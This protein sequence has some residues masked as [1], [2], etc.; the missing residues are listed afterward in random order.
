MQPTDARR[1][2]PDHAHIPCHTWLAPT[3]D[4]QA[5]DQTK[6]PATLCALDTYLRRA[7]VQACRAQHRIRVMT[8]VELLTLLRQMNS[9]ADADRSDLSLQ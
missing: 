9:G 1:V 7:D 3:L 5:T 4:G 6:P 2:R 8:D